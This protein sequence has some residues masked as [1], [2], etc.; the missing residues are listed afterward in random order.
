MRHEGF[1]RLPKLHR[2][3]GREPDQILGG[4]GRL[5]ESAGRW[6]KCLEPYPARWR[7]AHSAGRLPFK[8]IIHVAGINML[9]Q[10]S[11]WSIQDSIR[12]AIYAA[13][14]HRFTS[15]AFLDRSGFWELRSRA[16]KNSNGRRNAEARSAA[17]SCNCDLQEMSKDFCCRFL[18]T[19]CSATTSFA[20]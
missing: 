7:S 15:I 17:A 2:K 12:N 8:A 1:V 18:Q 13:N 11:E 14:E 5:R 9:W 16:G 6:Y 4:I 10:A 3:T 19:D 20:T